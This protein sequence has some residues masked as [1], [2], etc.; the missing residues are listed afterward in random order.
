MSIRFPK[1]CKTREQKSALA[2]L[3]ARRR[4]DRVH[5]GM[6]V[7]PVRKQRVLVALTVMRLGVDPRPALIQFVDDGL[8]RRRCVEEDGRT[9]NGLYGR[10][11]LVKWFGE[12]L[13]SAGV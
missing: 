3:V 5:E 10:K 6:V 2:S 8:H 12:V 7:E 13:R 4:W 1:S 9:W 11:A